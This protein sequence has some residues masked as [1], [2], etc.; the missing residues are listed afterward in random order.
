VDLGVHQDGLVQ[1]SKMSKR[2]IKHP[3]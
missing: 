2:Y 1:I 3:L